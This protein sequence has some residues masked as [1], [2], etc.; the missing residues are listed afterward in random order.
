M[1]KKYLCPWVR[2]LLPKFLISYRKCNLS[3]IYT[4]II[5]L[6]LYKILIQ[7]LK[8]KI[9]EFCPKFKQCSFPKEILFKARTHLIPPKHFRAVYTYF[10][11]FSFGW[12]AFLLPARPGLALSSHFD[13]L[14][15]NS[16]IRGGR[17]SEKKCLLF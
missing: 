10:P 9:K 1:S 4:I 3:N 15:I 13:L 6:F 14:H 2:N 8:F 12:P 11:C 17:V 7:F 5:T 16:L